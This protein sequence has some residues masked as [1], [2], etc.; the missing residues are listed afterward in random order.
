MLEPIKQ[1]I[2]VSRTCIHHGCETG[3]LFNLT[4]SDDTLAAFRDEAYQQQAKTYETRAVIVVPNDLDSA[5]TDVFIVV[6]EELQQKLFPTIEE[7]HIGELDQR[8]AEWADFT[9]Q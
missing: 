4:Q 9:K 6:P 3:W 7:P 5:C 2:M 8:Q 1:Y